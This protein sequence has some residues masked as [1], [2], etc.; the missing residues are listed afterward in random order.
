V[1]LVDAVEGESRFGRFAGGF[2]GSGFDDA[3]EDAAD[4]GWGPFRDVPELECGEKVGFLTIDDSEL[5]GS[6]LGNGEDLAAG[7]PGAQ[8]SA[9]AL[10]VA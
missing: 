8:E 6:R 9:D 1:E 7:D 2:A 4:L 5:V 3:F 10:A